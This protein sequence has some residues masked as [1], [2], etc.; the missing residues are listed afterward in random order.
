MYKYL[1]GPVLSRRLGVS[2]GVDLV[3][4]KICSFDCVYCECGPTTLLTTDRKEYVP[5]E[6]VKQELDFYWKNN[7]DPD[8][9]TFSGSG[10]PTLNNTIG[11]V[12]AYIKTHRPDIKVA[13]LTNGSL[14]SDPAVRKELLLADMVMPSFDAALVK[15]FIKINRPCPAIDS[16]T[17]LEGL[18]AF[19][20]EFKGNLF[21]EVL[22]LPGYNDKEEDLIA[23]NNA[24]KKINP[25]QVQLN[26]LD[27]PGALPGLEAASKDSLEAVKSFLDHDNVHI[28]AAAKD[29]TNHTVFRRDMI[30]AIMETISRRPC[31]AHDLSVILGASIDDI[32]KTLTLL[33][34]QGKI[35]S[36]LQERGLFFQTRKT[37]S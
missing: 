30:D 12:I 18:E 37:H 15:G 25:D 32:N 21:L 24:I 17:Y 20:K 23:L 34:N 4:H 6:I 1:F 33:S 16:G 10:E 36:V 29:Q 7:P 9:I 13:V 31:T 3:T 14:L 19:S 35:E 8:Y 22:I 5:F 26:T 11:R 28:I 2:L 27:R